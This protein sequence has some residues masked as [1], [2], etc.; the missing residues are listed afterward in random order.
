MN[1]AGTLTETKEL[2]SLMLQESVGAVVTKSA[3]LEPREG[4]ERPRFFLFD[5][6]SLNSMGL[7][8]PGF[9]AYA[10][11][12]I[13]QPLSKP[14]IHSLNPFSPGEL[15]SM[16]SI[17]SSAIPKRPLIVEVNLSCPN[18]RP[19]LGTHTLQNY[20]ET[21]R[22][23]RRPGLFVGVK[24]PPLVSNEAVDE[25][26][27][28][29]LEYS[30]SIAF[31]TCCNTLPNCLV[32]NLDQEEARLTPN[33]GLG[34]LGGRLLKPLALANVYQF[35]KRLRGSG[36]KIVG[37]GG[38]ETGADAFEFILCGAH[39]VQIGTHLI[40]TGPEC[41]KTVQADLQKLMQSKHYQRLHQFRGH[42][43]IPAKL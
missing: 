10:D 23:Q 4:N 26:A 30:D 5:E 43:S 21:L 34:G 6:G 20:L 28:K 42:L 1:A 24:L 39:L 33:G 29:L 36:I 13:S 12:A 32:V 15:D 19:N 8:N 2:D 22:R 7:P 17:L 40:R 37:C 27:R 14:L 25:V 41:F 35:A 16:L 3:T 9:R 38:V 11:H 31:V 18:V